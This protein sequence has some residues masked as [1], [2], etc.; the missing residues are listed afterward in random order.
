MN[1][2]YLLNPL[3]PDFKRVEVLLT[4]TFKYD[5]RLWK[6]SVKETKRKIGFKETEVISGRYAQILSPEELLA[7]SG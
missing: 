3:H 2:N 1:Y 4:E 5:S 6:A 7:R